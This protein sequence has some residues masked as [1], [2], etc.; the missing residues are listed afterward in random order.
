MVDVIELGGQEYL[1]PRDLGGFDAYP[2]FLLV[3]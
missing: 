1:G 2:D 3:V